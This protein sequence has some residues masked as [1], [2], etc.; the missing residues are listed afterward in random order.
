MMFLVENQ[1]VRVDAIERVTPAFKASVRRVECRGLDRTVS[2]ADCTTD[3]HCACFMLPMFS[4]GLCH[5]ANQ[6]GWVL[7][8]DHFDGYSEHVAVRGR[9]MP[10]LHGFSGWFIN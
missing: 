4:F 8:A 3:R 7:L 10:R 2:P 5:G 9:L 6:P 1:C